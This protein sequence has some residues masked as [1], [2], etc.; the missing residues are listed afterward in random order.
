MIEWDARQRA[1]R[2]G[3]A[4]WHERL[5]A[6]P[7]ERSAGERFCWDK[8]ELIR[9]SGILRLPFERG[10]GGLGEDLL[11]TM[12]LLESLG[13]GCGDGGLVFSACT[14]IVSAGVPLQRFGSDGLKRRYMARLCDGS[15]IGAH[16]ITEPEGGSDALGMRTTAVRDGERWVLA[17]TKAF[18]TNGP[19]ADVFVVYARTKPEGGPF[20]LTAFV[21]DRETPGL[22]VGEPIPK[23]GLAG[24]PV[25]DLVLDGCEVGAANVV[26]RPGTGFLVLDHVMTWEILLSFVASVGGMQRRLE[27]CVAYARERRQFGRPIGAYQSIANKI[28]EMKIGVETARRWLYDTGAR[29]Q[30][31]EDI[32]SDLAIAKLLASEANVASALAAVQ[33]FGAN[34]YAT[35]YGLEADLRDAVGGTIYSGTSEIQRNKIARLLGLGDQPA[36]RAA[37]MADARIDAEEEAVAT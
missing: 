23:M 9:E 25:G 13:H 15:A 2:D 14:Q 26:A 8:W 12:Y 22:R 34:G 1:L 4:T 28:V 21:V 36:A 29:F 27:R 32:T 30:R 10:Y 17:G 37:T 24:S 3:F 6:V 19:V 20:G 35:E 33:I 18:V 5:A 7:G 16:A 31:G 11:T